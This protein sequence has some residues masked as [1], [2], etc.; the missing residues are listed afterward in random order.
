VH[1]LF[2]EAERVGRDHLG[3]LLPVWSTFQWEPAVLGALGALLI[4]GLRW[5]ILRTLAVCGL[6]G[7][8]VA[9]LT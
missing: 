2:A 4:F 8:A 5:P 7:L 3:L 6:A 9:V 1:T